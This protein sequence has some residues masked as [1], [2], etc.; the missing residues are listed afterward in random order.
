MS[1]NGSRVGSSPLVSGGVPPRACLLP[2][3]YRHVVDA[4]GLWRTFGFLVLAEA[5]ECWRGRFRLVI[6]HAQHLG[7]LGRLF[8][9]LFAGLGH[10]TLSNLMTT[11][12]LRSMP[13][14]VMVPASLSA[15]V[16]LSRST[17]FKKKRTR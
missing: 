5:R 11:W 15:I 13:R 14:M 8:G 2:R 12:P 10:F 1:K 3:S 4:A 17:S 7:R 16:T 6:G 9:G